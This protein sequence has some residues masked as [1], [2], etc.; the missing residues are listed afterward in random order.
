MKS[1]F[2]TLLANKLIHNNG[3]YA[4][5]LS[6]EIR[7]NPREIVAKLKKIWSG[8]HGGHFIFL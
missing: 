1:L 3:K 2:M 7:K 4:K 5:L 6:D 8:F